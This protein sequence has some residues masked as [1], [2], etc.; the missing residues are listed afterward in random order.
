MAR[1]LSRLSHTV[2][3]ELQISLLLSRRSSIS[4]HLISSPSAV[5]R[6]TSAR[7]VGARTLSTSVP[8]RSS[9]ADASIYADDGPPPVSVKTVT[10]TGVEL[11]D[12]L[13]LSS[14][15]IFLEGRVFLWEVPK[16]EGHASWPG[17]TT[18]HFKIFEVVVPRPE[19][20]FIGTGEHA[21]MPPLSLKRYLNDLGIQIDVMNSW[22]ACSTYNMLS[23]EGRRVACA[24]IP[25][26]H[27][28]WQQTPK[29][30]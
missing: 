16:I 17:W 1:P 20:L 2:R 30:S 12:G 6:P 18:D 14:A 9:L 26:T 10:S 4:R 11:L 24:I 27:S 5:S 28:A 21:V 13:V 25:E 15:C 23:E 8:S 29:E 3:K 7:L 19:V 22:N